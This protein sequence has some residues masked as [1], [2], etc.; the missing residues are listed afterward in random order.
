MKT[1]WISPE[2]KK[3]KSQANGL[4]LRTEQEAVLDYF[5]PHIARYMNK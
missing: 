1:L 3:N 5:N 4:Q 2:Q